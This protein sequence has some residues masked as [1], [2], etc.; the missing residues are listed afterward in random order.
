ML[1]NSLAAIV[2]H[3]CHRYS[4][5]QKQKFVALD[6]QDFPLRHST[7]SLSSYDNCSHGIAISIESAEDYKDLSTLS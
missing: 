2:V 7:A 6:V 4:N 1:H 5:F 3:R